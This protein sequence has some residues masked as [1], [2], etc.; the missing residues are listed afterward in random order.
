LPLEHN[1]SA[2]STD[3]KN[4]FQGKGERCPA[5]YSKWLKE[6]QTQLR[7]FE[8]ESGQIQRNLNKSKK[9]NKKTPIFTSKSD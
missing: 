7:E 4:N 6:R 1:Q 8:K 2:L 9:L 3:A 5:I